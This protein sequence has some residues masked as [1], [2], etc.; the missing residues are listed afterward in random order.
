M[1]NLEKRY[2]WA[3]GILILILIF[4][5]GMK[6]GDFRNASNQ[7][8]EIEL[9]NTSD[10]DQKV[11]D[12]G[13]SSIIQ[14]Y[15]TGAV[16]QPGV[17]KLPVD[18]RV[19]EAVELAKALPEANLQMINLAQK[20]D[21]GMAIVVPL[22]GEEPTAM[23]S[24]GIISGA[25]LS[26]GQTGRVNINTASVQELDDKLPGIGP[27]IAQRI[28]DY[29]SLHGLFA[30][31]EDLNQVSGIGDKKFAELKELITVR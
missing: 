4:T 6:Y 10:S 9:E 8:Q 28:V 17:Y 2:L 18:A 21:D 29:R 26:A 24:T 13:E 20:L 7:K 16:A 25:S 31:P 30:K 27:T 15:V 12:A 23:V 11:E 14:V 22:A 19:V 1:L 3:A 5:L